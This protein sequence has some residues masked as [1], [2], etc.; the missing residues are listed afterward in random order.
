MTVLA[1]I[2][3]CIE[4]ELLWCAGIAIVH[5]DASYE[6]TDDPNCDVP[7]IAHEHLCA[8]EDENCCPR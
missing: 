8:C 6:C 3:V 1:E 7:A 2:D 4:D 5:V